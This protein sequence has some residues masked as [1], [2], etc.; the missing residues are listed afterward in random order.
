MAFLVDRERDA[1][2]AE[3]V[4]SWISAQNIGGI[5]PTSVTSHR[6]ED[7]ASEPA[8]WFVVRLPNPR[9]ELGTWPVDVLNDFDRAVRDKAIDEQL[10]WPWY[11]TYLPEN[12]EEQ[13]DED[14][15]PTNG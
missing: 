15:P 8:W 11:V 6:G 4:R 9:P 3:R 7:M 14:Q 5:R 10:S 1:E 2:T 12:D 13:E